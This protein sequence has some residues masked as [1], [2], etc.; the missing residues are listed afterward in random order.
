MKEYVASKLAIGFY[1]DG[2]VDKIPDIVCYDKDGFYTDVQGDKIILKKA[3]LPT[4][5]NKVIC[6]TTKVFYLFFLLL[7]SC[8]RGW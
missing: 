7:F 4:I 6:G 8:L 1:F 2:N 5:A 3:L